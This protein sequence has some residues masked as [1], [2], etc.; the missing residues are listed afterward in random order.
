MFGNKAKSIFEKECQNYI[1]RN[2]KDFDWKKEVKGKVI[3]NVVQFSDDIFKTN[4]VLNENIIFEDENNNYFAIEG[5]AE[6]LP[7]KIPY[8]DKEIAYI[9]SVVKFYPINLIPEKI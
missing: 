6:T 8:Q 2:I 3:E 1:F 9:V 5:N 7:I 4:I